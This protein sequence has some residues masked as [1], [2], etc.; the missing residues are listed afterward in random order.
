MKKEKLDAY[1]ET[2]RDTTEE[3]LKAAKALGIAPG[4]R[5]VTTSQIL[6]LCGVCLIDTYDEL[7]RSGKIDCCHFVDIYAR[8]RFLEEYLYKHT[9]ILKA[10]LLIPRDGEEKR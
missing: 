10:Q 6:A 7:I 8:V 4:E 9:G 1:E 5:A 3:F 2:A